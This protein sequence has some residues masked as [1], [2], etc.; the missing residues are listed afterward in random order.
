[1][2]VEPWI[3]VR[4]SLGRSPKVVRILSALRADISRTGSVG[5]VDKLRVV[6]GLVAVWALFDEQSEDGNLVGYS[7][8][9]L[10]D[11]VGLPGL[12]AAMVAVEW[13]FVDGE[14]LALPRFEDHNGASAKRRANDANRKQSVR[15]TSASDA[16]KSGT[17]SGPRERVRV[18][19]KTTPTP[20]GQDAPATPGKEKGVKKT[21]AA[22]LA[23]LPDGA[24][25]IQPADP[26][27]EY[28]ADAG[29]PADYLSLGWHEFRQ[30]HIDRPD[31]KQLDWV[32]TFRNYVRLN[33]LQLWQPCATGGYELTKKGV[34]AH[35]AREAANGAT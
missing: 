27:F 29:I 23:S 32:A 1:M 24:K 33:Y 19:N 9:A 26:I 10:D 3:K 35:R 18:R 13:L 2:A 15:K 11:E 4:T 7:T 30:Y 22:W 5:F 17:K 34:Q 6:G 12:S 25:A 20:S 28:A 14:T 31:K 16:D 21:I 8:E